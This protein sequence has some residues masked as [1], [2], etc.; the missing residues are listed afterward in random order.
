M[1]GEWD[2]S[3]GSHVK[4]SSNIGQVQANPSQEQTHSLIEELRIRDKVDEEVDLD[5]RD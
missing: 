2:V 1:V 3:G 4:E 5:D